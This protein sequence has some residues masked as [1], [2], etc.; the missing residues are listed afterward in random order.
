MYQVFF[1]RSIFF[2]IY[3]L[4][5]LLALS[6]IFTFVLQFSDNLIITLLFPNQTVEKS[7]FERKVFFVEIKNTRTQDTS[8]ETHY[9]FLNSARI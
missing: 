9:L 1:G 5:L 2:W 8:T 6:A 3:Q 7:P 4:M